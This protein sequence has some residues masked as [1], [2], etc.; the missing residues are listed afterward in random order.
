MSCLCASDRD[1]GSVTGCSSH[2]CDTEWTSRWVVKW[3]SGAH[4]HSRMPRRSSKQRTLCVPHM[5][6]AGS[7]AL[8]FA[9]GKKADF[10]GGEEDSVSDRLLFHLLK[11]FTRIRAWRIHVK[12]DLKGRINK[13]LV[14]TCKQFRNSRNL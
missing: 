3:D 8:L 14:E 9:P 1:T 13:T 4:A 11:F 5:K 12:I 2:G 6:E 7:D 10:G